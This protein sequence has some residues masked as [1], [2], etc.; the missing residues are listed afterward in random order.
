MKNSQNLDRFMKAQKMVYPLALKEIK[1]G[2]KR[3]HW[4]W[5]IFPQFKGLGFSP[6]SIKYAI[7]SKQEA[8]DFFNDG[9]LGKNLLE[10]TNAFLSIEHQSALDILGKSDVVKMKS[11]MTL[12]DAI[13]N[14]TAIFNDVLD[15]YFNGNKCSKTIKY[16]EEY[17]I[18]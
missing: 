17:N 5:Y 4:M 6:T 15:K 14:D 9:V 13:Q 7:N 2:R 18:V 10:I 1:R 3:S 11:C 8:I 12:F 16:L